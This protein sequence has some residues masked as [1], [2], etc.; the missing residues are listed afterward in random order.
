MVKNVTMADVARA[1]NVHPST[2]SLALKKDLRIPEA[3]QL[4]VLKAANE[5][6]YRPNPYV[7][8]L[9]AQRRSKSPENSTATLAFITEFETRDGWK[10]S[11]NYLH[12]RHFLAKHAGNRGYQVEDFWLH[13]PGL[14]PERLKQIFETRNIRGAIIC[15]LA[16]DNDTL[17]FDFSDMVAVTIGYSLKVP[18][19]NRVVIDYFGLVQIAINALK[20][21]G[22]SR[23]SFVSSRHIDHRVQNLSK[24]AYLAKWQEDPQDF[25]FPLIVPHLTP[26]VFSAWYH[27]TKPQT[28]LAA[29]RDTFAF[30][31]KW[32]ENASIHI[33]ADLSLVCL[34]KQAGGKEAGV[35]QHLEK[36]ASATIELLT[37]RLEHASFGI[38]DFAQVVQVSGIWEPGW[39]A[40]STG[41]L[42]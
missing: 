3:T 15:P 9:I 29:S 21:Q 11:R 38:P 6:G 16:A 8:A 33:P 18:T 28:I 23:F 12:L 25:L 41:A 35:V 42:N 13:E 30:I 34:D 4:R 14:S 19:L 20:K 32:A 22:H 7:S 17:E 37:D 36:E 10:A 5:M 2:V 39:S 31:Q 26:E 27:R 40:G 24:A 1:L